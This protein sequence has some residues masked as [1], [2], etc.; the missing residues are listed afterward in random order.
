LDQLLEISMSL[1]M[2]LIKIAGLLVGEEV[3]AEALGSA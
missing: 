3:Q 1:V 2:R